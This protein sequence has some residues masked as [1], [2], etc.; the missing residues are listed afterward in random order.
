MK[1]FHMTHKNI[2]IPYLFYIF[3]ITLKK[4][5]KVESF[6]YNVLILH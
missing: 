5:N 1:L 3:N 2:D 4:Q 6:F